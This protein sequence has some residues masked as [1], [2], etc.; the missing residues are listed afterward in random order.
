M[1]GYVNLLKIEAYLR[2]RLPKAQVHT[3]SQGCGRSHCI[4]SELS[5]RELRLNVPRE[6]LLAQIESVE[7]LLDGQRVIQRLCESPD[8]GVTLSATGLNGA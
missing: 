2:K 3:E 1:S 5:G 4:V 7:R 6:F 8:H